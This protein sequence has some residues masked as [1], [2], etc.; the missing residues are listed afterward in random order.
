MLKEFKSWRVSDANGYQLHCVNIISSYQI[1][2]NMEA[3][4]IQGITDGVKYVTGKQPIFNTLYIED[5]N[6]S[7]YD[8]KPEDSRLFPPTKYGPQLVDPYKTNVFL[9]IKDYSRPNALAQTSINFS[10]QSIRVIEMFITKVMRNTQNPIDMLRTMATHEF[11][12]LHPL[13]RNRHCENPNC[14]M[15]KAIDPRVTNNTLCPECQIDLT[16][17]KTDFKF[18]HYTILRAIHDDLF[19]STVGQTARIL[20]AINTLP[21]AVNV[22]D[23][24][25][26]PIYNVKQYYDIFAFK[27]S[28]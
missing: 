9:S 28:R 23:I 7:P 24:L 26:I 6:V 1:H 13:F 12:H 5:R 21:P 19:Y 27:G 18:W 11:L 17:F 22:N 15:F 20:D 8:F 2:T 14:L 25:D 3:S 16:K 4:V 10:Y